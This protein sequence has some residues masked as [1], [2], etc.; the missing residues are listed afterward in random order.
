MLSARLVR[1]I[2]QHSDEISNRL[3]DAIRA[4]HDLP[5]LASESDAELQQWAGDILQNL[6]HLL[7]APKDEATLSRYHLMGRL[8]FEESIPL[9]EAVLRLHLLKDKIVGFVH[10]QG[11]PMTSLQL[12][13]EE[14]LEHRICGF[15]DAAVY[16]VVRG[17]EDAMRVAARIDREPAT[18]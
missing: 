3:I 17:Y 14:E 9:H 4:H 18:R 10:E 1:L 12:Y 13:A 5:T 11:F 7:S 16:H 2:E 8:R 15:F 6:G